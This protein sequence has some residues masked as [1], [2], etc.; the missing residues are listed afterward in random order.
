MQQADA[1]HPMFALPEEKNIFAAM[2]LEPAEP[3]VMPEGH[4]DAQQQ[5]FVDEV[6][7][8]PALVASGDPTHHLK[9]TTTQ[10]P[11]CY[12]QTTSNCPGCSD[13][14]STCTHSYLDFSSDD[15]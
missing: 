7:G 3:V 4:Y 6:T 12:N 15:D 14:D 1:T 9:S 11:G 2:F 10:T 5:V 13:T 8:R